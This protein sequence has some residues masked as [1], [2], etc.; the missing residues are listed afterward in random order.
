MVR[1]RLLTITAMASR[2][3][4]PRRVDPLLD[5]PE[6]RRLVRQASL[7]PAINGRLGLTMEEVLQYA[8]SMMANYP[9]DAEHLLATCR[10]LRGLLAGE[11]RQAET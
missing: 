6:F 7:R 4:S 3:R 2:S 10:L 11:V 5:T 1:I 8:D 9:N